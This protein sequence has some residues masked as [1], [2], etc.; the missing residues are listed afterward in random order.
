[1][2]R[3]CRAPGC[4]RT[5]AS[6]Y[7][8][9]C[10]MHKRRVRRHGDAQQ[11]AV[12]V[13]ELRPYLD[14]VRRRI[15]SDPSNRTW[16]ILADRW[17]L[18]IDHAREEL[19]RMEQGGAYSRPA[20]EAMVAIVRVAD[21]IEPIAVIETVCAMYLM[22]DHRAGRFVSDLAFSHQLVR[23]VRGLSRLNAGEYWDQRE[24]KRR[25]VY[26]DPTPRGAAVM[27]DLLEEAFG[28]V[29]LFLARLD[30]RDAD[31]KASERAALADALG[32]LR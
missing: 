28:G 30:Q 6:G 9:Y 4:D 15:K 12:T 14:R 22:R 18:L 26:K 16:P 17:Q 24:R 10:E 5:V 2:R 7:A 32:E 31:R 13:H 27:A 19:K 1:M 23:R 20:R 21:H 3:H 25:L 11:V 29:G 8:A